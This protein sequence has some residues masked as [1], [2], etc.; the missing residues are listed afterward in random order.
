M[1]IPNIKNN[2][3]KYSFFQ[4]QENQNCI[5]EKIFLKF[6]KMGI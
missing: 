1:K 3:D 6:L 2:T 5:S 4:F